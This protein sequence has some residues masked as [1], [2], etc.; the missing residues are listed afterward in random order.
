MGDT[1][2]NLLPATEAHQLRT[3]DSQATFARRSA[4]RHDELSTWWPLL[5]PR[6]ALALNLP[7]DEAI[8]TCLKLPARIDR[9]ADSVDVGMSLHHLP[10]SIRLAGLDRN[11]GWVPASGCDIRFHFEA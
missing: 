9:R 4:R 8:A 7:E 1:P 2:L 10:L 3:A 6:L 5:G 11:P